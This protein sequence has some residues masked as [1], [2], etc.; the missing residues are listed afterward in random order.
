MIHLGVY[1]AE[2]LVA[3]GRPEAALTHIENALVQARPTRSTKYVAKCHALRGQ[4][5]LEARDWVP[6]ESDLREAL[7]RARAI[8]SKINERLETVRSSTPL[9][10]QARQLANDPEVQQ[11]AQVALLRTRQATWYSLIGVVVS[12]ITVI[13]GSLAGAGE[14]PAPVTVFGMRPRV[15]PQA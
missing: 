9:P 14:L 11:A 2:T 10:D 15:R 13:L 12:M 6:A 4:I 1:L 7:S 8:Q 3:M 5:A